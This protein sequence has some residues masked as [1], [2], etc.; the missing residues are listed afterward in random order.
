SSWQLYPYLAEFM[1]EHDF[2]EGT[3]HLRDFRIMPT[4]WRRTLKPSRRIKLAHARELIAKFPGRRFVLVGD[5]GE[6]DVGT[7][8]RLYR[9]FPRQVER[10]FIRQVVDGRALSAKQLRQL[11]G[12]PSERWELFTRAQELAT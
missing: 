12:V 5:S 6:A 2:P 4:A 11:E 7:Y 8:A 1:R 10:I 3:F 9:E